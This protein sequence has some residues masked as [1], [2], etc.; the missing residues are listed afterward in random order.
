M[1]DFIKKEAVKG[2]KEIISS[3]DEHADFLAEIAISLSDIEHR[4]GFLEK[5]SDEKDLPK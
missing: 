3:I 4:L 2:I 1:H 5:L